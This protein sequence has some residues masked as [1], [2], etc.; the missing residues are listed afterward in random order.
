MPAK[1]PGLDGAV[2][3]KLTNG[4]P[5][6]VNDRAVY[7]AWKQGR[8]VP[9]TLMDRQSLRLGRTGPAPEPTPK[10]TPTKEGDK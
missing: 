7:A 8:G 1:Y 9:L 2:A 6:S 5:L 4:K 10:P 3:R